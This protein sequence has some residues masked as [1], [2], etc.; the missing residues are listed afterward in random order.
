[1]ADPK[2]FLKHTRELPK[3]RNPKKR[4][5]GVKKC[6]EKDEKYIFKNQKFAELTIVKSKI[7][8]K[9]KQIDYHNVALTNLVFH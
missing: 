2:G 9:Y 7:T 6:L 8:N 5:N 1:M 3:S 4:I